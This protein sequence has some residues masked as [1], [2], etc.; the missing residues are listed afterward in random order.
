MNR[1]LDFNTKC[2]VAINRLLRIGCVHPSEPSYVALL[3]TIL[4]AGHNGQVTE[5]TIDANNVISQLVDLKTR[6]KLCASRGAAPQPCTLYPTDA[7]EFKRS[8]PDCYKMAYGAE[9]RCPSKIDEAS[10]DGL[11]KALPARKTHSSVTETKLQ[12]RRGGSA[13]ELRANPAE[14]LLMS[15]FDR[16]VGPQNTPGL[17]IF[18]SQG[19]RNGTQGVDAPTSGAAGAI[20]DGS[21]SATAIGSASPALAI[22]D[23][24]DSSEVAAQHPESKKCLSTEELAEEF[25]GAMRRPAAAKGAAVKR[26]AAATTESPAKAQKTDGKH[27]VTPKTK[28]K[29]TAP[30]TTPTTPNKLPYPGT[31]YADPVH[32]GKFT[33]YTA[34]ADKKWR[35][36]PSWTR[37]D[38]AFSWKVD[39]PKEVWARV[40][41]YI[42]S[43][44]K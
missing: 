8:Y 20:A 35:V 39:D 12:L 3:A 38:K 34:T 7:E 13:A 41:A 19:Q 36:K 29:K 10:V 15:M 44:K 31:A 37:V 24:E 40:C 27:K 2:V 1:N 9:P 16:L 33:I 11:R 21:P 5:M 18:G 42:S 6:Y 4:L 43:S 32:V 30:A 17:Q 26:P 25:R 23:K 22:E 28:N 14:A